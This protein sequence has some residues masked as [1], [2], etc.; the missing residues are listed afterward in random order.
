VKRGFRLLERA[1]VVGL[2][3]TLLTNAALA[4]DHGLEHHW[5]SPVYL[6]EI[7]LQIAAISAVT[8]FW[9]I[10]RIIRRLWGAR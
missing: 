6:R 4:G 10:S 7:R 3:P 2:L 5:S 1:G 8:F 9:G